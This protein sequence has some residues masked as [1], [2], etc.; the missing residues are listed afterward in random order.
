MVVHMMTCTTKGILGKMHHTAPI[1]ALK[2]C[3][4]SLWYKPS[5]VVSV[6]TKLVLHWYTLVLFWHSRHQ[7][8]PNDSMY[9]YT[10]VDS[11]VH[12]KRYFGKN[13]PHSSNT[14]PQSMYG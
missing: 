5:L 7:P 11:D 6:G 10:Y 12:R 9:T 4:D 1:L 13:A 2:A 14:S 8:H 3:T